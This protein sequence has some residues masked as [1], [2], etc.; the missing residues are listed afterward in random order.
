MDTITSINMD[1]F[2]P[3]LNKDDMMKDFMVIASKNPN[4]R[5]KLNCY[6]KLKCDTSDCIKYAMYNYVIES[7]NLCWHCALCHKKN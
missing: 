3:S 6:D 1:L 7:K 2:L 5:I 4:Y